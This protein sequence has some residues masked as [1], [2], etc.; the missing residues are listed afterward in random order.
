MSTETIKADGVPHVLLEVETGPSLTVTVS[1]NDLNRIL[2]SKVTSVSASDKQDPISESL[3]IRHTEEDLIDLVKA[4]R[5]TIPN[6]VE[7]RIESAESVSHIHQKIGSSYFQRKRED[8]IPIRA[9]KDIREKIFT[10][11]NGD[12]I[13]GSQEVQGTVPNLK[14]ISSKS[15]NHPGLYIMREQKII[16]AQRQINALSE[17]LKNIIEVQKATVTQL[18]ELTDES[19]KVIQQYD[20][21]YS[22]AET[23]YGELIEVIVAVKSHLINKERQQESETGDSARILAVFNKFLDK[24]EDLNVAEIRNTLNEDFGE[25]RSIKTNIGNVQSKMPEESESNVISPKSDIRKRIRTDPELNIAMIELSE[26]E[27]ETIFSD[28]DQQDDLLG[29]PDDV[30]KSPSNDREADQNRNDADDESDKMSEKESENGHQPHQSPKAPSVK[31]PSPFTSGNKKDDDQEDEPELNQV[32][33]ADNKKRSRIRN[34]TNE[35]FFPIFK[36]DGRQLIKKINTYG[37]WLRKAAKLEFL[38]NLAEDEYGQALA[39]EMAK[40]DTKDKN[41]V[42]KVE[43]GLTALEKRMKKARLNFTQTIRRLHNRWALFNGFNPKF[44]L[45][46]L[47][48]EPPFKK[49]DQIRKGLK[50]KDRDNVIKIA[51]GN[52]YKSN[53]KKIETAI[54]DG[55]GQ[56]QPFP[57]EEEIERFRDGHFDGEP[58]DDEDEANESEND[59]PADESDD[60]SVNVHSSGKGKRKSGQSYGPSL[61][62]QK[63]VSDSE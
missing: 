56:I 46:Y 55:E 24:V 61:K 21:V 43:E 37:E 58:S 15:E 57:T 49:T 27:L 32:T 14:V 51:T 59:D 1:E 23:T 60:E 35:E 17:S 48:M 44:A 5:D 4:Y 40:I 52:Q 29:G 19:K 36:S 20:K 18:Q 42:K 45:T 31:E 11:E 41:A 34:R 33:P 16:E 38:K 13:A 22:V 3:T 54:K 30:R 39:K 12:N 28:K 8:L 26:K 6:S 50:K 2:H 63:R 62:A 10:I 7:K 47:R 25:K 53:I 9:L